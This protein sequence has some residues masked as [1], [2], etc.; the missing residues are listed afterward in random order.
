MNLPLSPETVLACKP[1]VGDL[2]DAIDNWLGTAS[3][4]R[5]DPFACL[6]ATN[7][8][9]HFGCDEG[10]SGRGEWGIV[11]PQLPEIQ[12]SDRRA[13]DDLCDSLSKYDRIPEEI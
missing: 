4:E 9:H 8:A 6:V 12:I 2:K 3:A 1:W 5:P 7:F 13:L 10:V 11:V